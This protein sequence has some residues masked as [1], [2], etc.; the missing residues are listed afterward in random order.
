MHQRPDVKHVLLSHNNNNLL[1][2][3]SIKSQMA[4][5]ANNT[6]N[7]VVSLNITK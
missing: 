4:D 7:E 3:C 1:L 6:K 5:Y 2:V